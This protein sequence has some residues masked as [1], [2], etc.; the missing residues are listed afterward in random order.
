MNDTNRP[1]MVLA[2]DAL[3][4]NHR[5]RTWSQ[6][7][8]PA[9]GFYTGSGAEALNL[10]A[11]ASLEEAL[12]NVSDSPLSSKLDITATMVHELR[13]VSDMPMMECKHALVAC[14]G[15]MGKATEYLRTKGRNLA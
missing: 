3:R 15:D 9:L 11:I 10:N 2:L 13:V 4:Q 6:P 14:D 7:S 1:V 8:N 5:Y 12:S